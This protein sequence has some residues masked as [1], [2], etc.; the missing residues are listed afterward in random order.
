MPCT[1]AALCK[2]PKHS[3][4]LKGD[5][6]CSLS[7]V[8]AVSATKSL[9]SSNSRP[10]CSRRSLPPRAGPHWVRPHRADHCHSGQADLQLSR[11]VRSFNPQAVQS[12]MEIGDP[13]ADP[14]VG[15]RPLHIGE[16]SP[17]FVDTRNHLYDQGG[18]GKA[19]SR[20]SQSSCGIRLPRKSP[21][22]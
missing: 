2:I 10:S 16:T 21:N 6:Q 22:S 1:Q 14:P 3:I 5:E 18:S 15:I 19:P 12:A 11:E 20:Q 13:A 7:I 8:F 9:E 17:T 4:C